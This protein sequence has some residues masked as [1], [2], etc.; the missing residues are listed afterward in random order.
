MRGASAAR[1]PWGPMQTR[2]TL[3][4]SLGLIAIV[5][6]FGS[7]AS[8]AS[9]RVVNYW[10]AAVPVTWNIVPNGHDAIM[11][12]AYPTA[13]TVFPTVVYRNFTKNWRHALPNV[14]GDSSNQDLIPGPL[15][16]A[17]VGDHILVHL[18]NM[19][20]LYR[21]VHSMHFHGVHYPP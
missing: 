12:T 8:A 19:D 5:V 2:R 17:R 3:R 4:W 7:V 9:A 13:D 15:I 18:K 1:M 20:M 16:R 11:G 6:G 14:P 10:V 21:R